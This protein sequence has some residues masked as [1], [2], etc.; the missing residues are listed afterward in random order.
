MTLQN[1]SFLAVFSFDNLSFSWDTC[2]QQPE[3]KNWGSVKHYS[4]LHMQGYNALKRKMLFD[5]GMNFME[6]C[7][8]SS[9]FINTEISNILAVW[10]FFIL[11]AFLSYKEILLDLSNLTEYCYTKEHR[12]WK[13]KF[14]IMLSCLW[15]MG[16]PYVSN[17]K[18]RTLSYEDYITNLRGCCYF[19][20]WQFCYFVI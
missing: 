4:S 2:I 14:L 13:M 20:L 9:T 6:H 19:A 12:K 1:V 16:M 8:W 18:S 3:H 5:E 15:L 17:A 7:F 10:Q 11:W